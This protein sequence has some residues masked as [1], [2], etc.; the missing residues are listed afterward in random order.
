MPSHL[1][2]LRKRSIRIRIV[3]QRMVLKE[4]RRR[5]TRIAIWQLVIAHDST[6]ATSPILTTTITADCGVGNVIETRLCRTDELVYTAAS[7]PT[8]SITKVTNTCGHSAL[9]T[10]SFRETIAT[11]RVMPGDELYQAQYEVACP[12][13]TL[14]ASIST[15]Q[16]VRLL[17]SITAMLMS[18]ILW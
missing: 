14:Q 17:S 5:N 3:E 7:T 16:M 12:S 18:P 2:C 10:F 1:D 13:G 15:E 6:T 9:R 4:I 8:F 11:E